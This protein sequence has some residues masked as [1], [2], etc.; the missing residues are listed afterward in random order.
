[1]KTMKPQMTND[2]IPQEFLS[3]QFKLDL[4]RAWLE[5]GQEEL[6]RSIVR[7]IIES[8]EDTTK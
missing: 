2:S 3:V 7:S 4:A 5:N 6:A 8:A 1:M